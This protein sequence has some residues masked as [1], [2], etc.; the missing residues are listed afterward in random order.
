MSNSSKQ[1]TSA[2]KVPGSSGA[3]K[4]RAGMLLK[5]ARPVKAKPAA[6]VAKVRKT[7]SGSVKHPQQKKK[8]IAVQSENEDED[9]SEDYPEDGLD[10][11]EDEDDDEDATP[12][13]Q[14]FVQELN[15]T[16]KRKG[17]NANHVADDD[18]VDEDDDDEVEAEDDDADD[19]DVDDEDQ[20][21]LTTKV[22]KRK[23]KDAGASFEIVSSTPSA[24]PGRKTAGRAPAEPQTPSGK[25]A[26]PATAPYTPFDEKKNPKDASKPLI[27][28][29]TPITRNILK[30]GNHLYRANVITKNAFPDDAQRVEDA[31]RLF[32]QVATALDL[33]RRVSRF[34][35][36]QAYQEMA[37]KIIGR[38]GTQV[39]GETAN[40]AREIVGPHYGLGASR[41][42]VDQN[43]LYV[44]FLLTQGNFLY[45]ELVSEEVDATT[46]RCTKRKGPY[47]NS[48]LE[49]L[50]QQEYFHGHERMAV[51]DETKD[52]FNP[53]PLAAVAFAA[54]AVQ[55]ALRDWTTGVRVKSSSDFSA[56]DW[57]KVYEGHL[58]EL[59]RMKARQPLRVDVW[60]RKIWKDAWAT[61]RQQLTNNDNETSFMTPDEMDDFSDVVADEEAPAA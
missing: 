18:D 32:I 42:S 24:L 13:M 6:A 61:T 25:G 22:T 48:I 49:Q 38:A 1:A 8:H 21:Q 5:D 7:T 12:E 40:A 54:T 31:A 29:Q 46:L 43:K 57:T 47:R 19:N 34:D 33:P 17:Y 11:E 37:I 15:S 3:A 28:L 2:R 20:L 59:E 23:R 52:L 35:G 39:R 58:R 56:D 41:G 55:C 44:E 9:E 14:S 60:M 50:L 30:K 26:A 53:M 36:D 27:S 51:A 10:G 4:K 45:R 16:G